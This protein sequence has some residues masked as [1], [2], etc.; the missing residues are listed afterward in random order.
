MNFAYH[1]WIFR[2][3]QWISGYIL[4]RFLRCRLFISAEPNCIHL[5]KRGEKLASHSLR[6]TMT[7]LWMN[8]GKSS[9]ESLTVAS[10]KKDSVL[11]D[12]LSNQRDLLRLLNFFGSFNVNE[13]AW[14]SGKYVQFSLFSYV[15][16]SLV[17]FDF[18]YR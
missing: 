17:I 4:K 5:L 13:I 15:T 3:T 1:V 14:I 11:M 7:K 6:M 16:W 2:F 10:L 9:T 18:K 8:E 12:Y